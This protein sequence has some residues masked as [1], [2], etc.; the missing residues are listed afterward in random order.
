MPVKQNLLVYTIIS[1]VVVVTI[2]IADKQNKLS[3]IQHIH[4]AAAANHTKFVDFT[5]ICQPT[6]ALIRILVR[7]LLCKYAPLAAPGQATLAL[8]ASG[9]V[10]GLSALK[11][12]KNSIKIIHGTL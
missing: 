6:N 2:Y 7:L 8:A 1:T 10:A 4:A 12:L 11:M 3:V 9:R 5:K